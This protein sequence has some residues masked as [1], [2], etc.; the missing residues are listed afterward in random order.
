MI[1]R[2][3]ALDMAMGKYKEF[4]DLGQMSKGE[5]LRRLEALRDQPIPGMN[6]KTYGS[7]HDTRIRKAEQEV[8]AANRQ[9]WS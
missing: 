7:L 8:A 6:G 9:N 4:V 1:G 3:A 5:A 2:A